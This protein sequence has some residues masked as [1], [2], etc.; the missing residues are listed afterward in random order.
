VLAAEATNGTRAG[1]PCKELSYSKATISDWQTGLDVLNVAIGDVL[2]L[3][4]S[5]H[6]EN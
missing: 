4:G 6:L 2:D 3:K 1:I 5:E